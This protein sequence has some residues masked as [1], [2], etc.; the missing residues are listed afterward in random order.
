MLAWRRTWT[1]YGRTW[2]SVARTGETTMLIALN[3][4]QGARYIGIAEADKTQETFLYGWLRN[5][6][7]M[8]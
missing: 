8:A 6:V 2:R 5:R 3:A 1:R 4:L 7:Q